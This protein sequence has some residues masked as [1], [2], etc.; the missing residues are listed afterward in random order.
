[1]IEAQVRALAG[2]AR[3]DTFLAAVQLAQ[4]RGLT[5]IVETGCVRT[6]PNSPDGAST[7]IWAEYAAAVGG[8]LTS[9]DANEHS[10]ATARRA[11][12]GLEAFVD[13]VHADSVDAFREINVPI[14]VLYLDSLDWDPAAPEP[15][16][17]HQL[18]ELAAAYRNLTPDSI[19]LLDDYAL[20]GKGKCGLGVPWLTLRGWRMAAVGYQC[21]L[22]RNI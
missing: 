8:R 19:I 10:I 17:L 21:L 22:V 11:V 2:S 15:A 9:I 6:W 14:G 3:T 12:E 5:S 13:L 4:Q 7:R 16:Q 1:M 18:A 20:P